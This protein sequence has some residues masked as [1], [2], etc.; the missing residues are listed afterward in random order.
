MKALKLITMAFLLVVFGLGS[1]ACAVSDEE[2]IR[3]T[4]TS[5]FAAYENQEYSRALEFLS[6]LLKDSTGEAEIIETMR[7]A[8]ILGDFTKLKSMGELEIDFNTATIW[9]DLEGFADI[10]RTTQV[11]LVKEDGIWKI[12]GF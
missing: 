10:V 5:F 9:V 4:V 6:D 2:A 7:S 12:H 1:L 11:S 3:E 8:Q